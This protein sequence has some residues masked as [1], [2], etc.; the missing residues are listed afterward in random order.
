MSTSANTLSRTTEI[1]IRSYRRTIGVGGR[2]LFSLPFMTFGFFHIMGAQ[3]MAGYVPA[4]IPGSG[5][6]WILLTGVAL[7]AA[8]VSIAANR[9]VWL[10][11]PLLALM[12]TIFVLTIHVPGIIEEST[13]QMSMISALKDLGL[14]GGALFIASKVR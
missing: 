3:D 4:W 11:A 8:G 1:D 14:V 9:L 2:I 5:V 12:V 7:I 6:F 10:S 13:R